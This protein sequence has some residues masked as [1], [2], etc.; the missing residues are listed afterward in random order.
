MVRKWQGWPL[1]AFSARLE[2]VPGKALVSAR[3]VSA[4]P[5]AAQPATKAPAKKK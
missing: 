5:H 1:R 2:A 4:K 3:P